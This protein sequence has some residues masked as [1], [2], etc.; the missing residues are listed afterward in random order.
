MRIGKKIKKIKSNIIVVR[1]FTNKKKIK[2][3]HA[4]LTM[5]KRNLEKI[6]TLPCLIPRQ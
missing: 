2:K 1:F 6:N 4:N 3:L 5:N